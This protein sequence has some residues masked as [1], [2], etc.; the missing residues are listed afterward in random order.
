MRGGCVYQPFKLGWRQPSGAGASG[1][2][3]AEFSGIGA[4][5]LGSLV[6]YC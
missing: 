4:A 2:E 1:F 3:A 6:D 5:V